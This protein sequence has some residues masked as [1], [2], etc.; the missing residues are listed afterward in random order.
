MISKECKVVLMRWDALAGELFVLPQVN[1]NRPCFRLGSYLSIITCSSTVSEFFFFNFLLIFCCRLY[2]WEREGER[3]SRL[4]QLRMN[5]WM[6]IRI[7]EIGIYFPSR[8]F[9]PL[10]SRWASDSPPWFSWCIHRYGERVRETD[11]CM[12]DSSYLQQRQRL[13]FS[14]LWAH[15]L[16][17]LHFHLKKEED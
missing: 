9:Q 13:G 3:L 11:Q 10:Q 16:L 2:L 4:L 15:K 8:I 14:L 5:G 12:A 6:K 17:E 1:I 7:W